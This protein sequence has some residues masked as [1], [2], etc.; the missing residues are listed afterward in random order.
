MIKLKAVIVD[1]DP[2]VVGVI[3]SLIG[4]GHP[5]VEIVATAGDIVSG[6]N[7]I[8]VSGP[9]IVFLDI[10]LP[11]GTGFDLLKKLD[12]ITFKIIFV[13]AYEAYA[14]QA[15]KVCALDYLLKPV[16]PDE[17][18][19]AV[20]KAGEIIRKEDEQL[21][22]N[23]LLE[24]FDEKKTLKRIVLHTSDCLHYVNISEIIRCEADNNY[25]TFYLTNG[26]KILVSKTLKEYAELL[27]NSGFIRVHQSHLVNT[28]FIEKYIKTEGGYL[29][30]KDHTNIPVS[31]N[32]KQEVLNILS[33]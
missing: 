19:N 25:T 21:K 14:L 8:A 7:A 28:V 29:Q 2:K 9:D 32:R 31:L 3:S 27:K 5:E 15:I 4:Q 20:K 11:D 24:N 13:T 22:V 17:L 12:E 33:S 30:L 16:D 10:N 23:A 26:K 6:L 18:S 1:D